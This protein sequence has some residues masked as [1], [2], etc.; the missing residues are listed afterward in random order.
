MLFCYPTHHGKIIGGGEGGKKEN[1]HLSHHPGNPPTPIN[2][3]KHPF[4]DKRPQQPSHSPTPRRHDA[5]HE[6]RVETRETVEPGAQGVHVFLHE[7]EAA[8][9]GGEGGEEGGEEG[10]PPAEAA[11]G[12]VGVPG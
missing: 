7:E 2:N 4:P 11:E 9:C 6:D 3:P 5:E 8:G 1:T 12:E 10:V